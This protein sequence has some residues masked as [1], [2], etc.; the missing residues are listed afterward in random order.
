[1]NSVAD[2]FQAFNLG[3]SAHKTEH[4]NRKPAV[5][6]PAPGTGPLAPKPLQKLDKFL[7]LEPVKESG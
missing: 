4:F 7:Q 2:G 1:V 3:L 5:T 6:F